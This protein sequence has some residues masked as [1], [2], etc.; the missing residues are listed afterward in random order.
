MKLLSLNNDFIKGSVLLTLMFLMSCTNDLA[1]VK[2]IVSDDDLSIEI[3]KNIEMLYSD[4]AQVKVRI[5]SPTLKRYSTQQE[6]YDEFPDGLKVEFL[7]KNQQ[8]TSWLE[9]NYAIKKE[10][11]SK[12][13]IEDNVVL[14]NRREEKLFTEELV[15]DE[16]NEIVYTNKA[17]KIVQP[18]IGDTSFGFGFKA[19]QEFT[20]FEISRSFSA[21]KN[22][23]DLTNEIQ[24]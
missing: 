15:W 17:V 18:A 1:E 5:L 6:T 13:Y 21:I 7:N 24:N 8:A 19:D 14:Y 9:A 10:K 22:V 2:K 20:R 4:S 11:D 16:A 12:I 3:A 23:E